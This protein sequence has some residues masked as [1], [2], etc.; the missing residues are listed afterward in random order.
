MRLLCRGERT[1]SSRNSEV[2]VSAGRI[3]TVVDDRAAPRRRCART[4]GLV[5]TTAAIGLEASWDIAV[6]AYL[7]AQRRS[8][9]A[10]LAW[11]LVLSLLPLAG[12]PLYL[13]IG[14][15][16]MQRRRMRYSSSRRRVT[17]ALPLP[18]RGA[19]P[20]PP[21]ALAA[22][23]VGEAPPLEAQVVLLHTG[24]ACRR[25]L[26]EAIGGARHHAHLEYFIFSDGAFAESLV[27]ALCEAAQ[28]GVEVRLLVD[29]LGSRT[30]SRR[31]RDRLTNAGAQVA[32]FNPVRL[33]GLR[34]WY[35][36]FRTHRKI[37]V[38]DGHVG[39]TGGMNVDDLHDDELTGPRAWADLHVRLEGEAVAALQ[40]VFLEDWCFATNELVEPAA[41]AHPGAAT[42]AVSS[43]VQIV[44]SGPDHTHFAIYKQWVAAIAGARRR[45]W[46]CTPYFVP[47]EAMARLLEAKA[48]SG[49]DV[50]VL[51]PERSDHRF[52]ELAQR[53]FY[54]DLLAARGQVLE[55]PAPMLHA[56]VLVVDDDFA[57]VGTFNFD[58]RSFRLNFEVT[59]T[60]FTPRAVDEVAA[61]L[62]R[63]LDGAKPVVATDRAPVPH[64][65]AQGLARLVAPLL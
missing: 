50:R 65:V 15:R 31:L 7:G 38:V 57:S 2:E 46:L 29:G 3:V 22:L 4:F 8:P 59:A 64:R 55:R 56:K 37:V 51:V 27:T 18:G 13:L 11:W 41:H 12:A 53:T 10:T 49:V 33:R 1:P 44:A 21:P 52:V 62:W 16:R 60:L 5:W 40:L 42:A 25:S 32:F 24:S 63:E 36:N 48:L 17:E 45:V 34:P 61:R 43:W 19:A 28:R 23:A 58:N 47:D 54:P 26:L 35:A 9:V 14:P 20:S 39:F 6:T 30:L